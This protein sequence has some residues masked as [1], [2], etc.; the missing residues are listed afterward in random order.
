MI[1]FDNTC[2]R[3]TVYN[4]GTC[5]FL[6][7]LCNHACYPYCYYIVCFHSF[8]TYLE[9]QNLAQACLRG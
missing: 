1:D 3:V 7:F 5:Q 4:A 8:N 6:L 9:L 2:D